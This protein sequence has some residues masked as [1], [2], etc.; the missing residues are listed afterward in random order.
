MGASLMS[1]GGILPQ[2]R[3]SVKWVQR[4]WVWANWLEPGSSGWPSRL[5]GATQ[6]NLLAAAV[7]TALLA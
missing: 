6:W 2:M 7:D 1:T 5:Y 4:R 3:W